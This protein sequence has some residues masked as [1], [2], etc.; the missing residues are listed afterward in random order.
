MMCIFFHKWDKW[1]DPEQRTY[2]EVVSRR[3][4]MSEVS[5]ES[6]IKTVQ[7]RICKKCGKLERRIF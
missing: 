1:S 3:Y 4:D 6:V 5:R 2:I 7:E